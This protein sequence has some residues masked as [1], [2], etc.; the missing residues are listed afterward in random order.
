MPCPSHAVAEPF[1]LAIVCCSSR[2]ELCFDINIIIL[3]SSLTSMTTCAHA[4]STLERL[5]KLSLHHTQCE[6]AIGHVANFDRA[7]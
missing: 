4:R 5:L 6:Q 2:I 3:G 7:L 1:S